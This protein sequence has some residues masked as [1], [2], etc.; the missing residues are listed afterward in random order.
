MMIHHP[1]NSE[2]MLDALSGRL[3]LIRQYANE[4]EPSEFERKWLGPLRRCAYWFSSMPL[5]PDQ[6][7]E[8]GGAFRATV[9]V[10]F[11]AM[12]LSGGQKFAADQPSERRRKIEPQY[13]H[14]LFL[15]AACSLLDEPCRHFQFHR[16]SDGTE[17]HPAAH[18]AFGAWI[19][20]DSYR[21]TRRPT[22]GQV[23]RM[24]TALLAREILGSDL[25]SP[26]D[27]AVLSEL[28]GAI[29]PEPRPLGLETLLQKVIRQAIAVTVDFE[30]K[31][32][33][34]E[35]APDSTRPPTSDQLAQAATSAQQPDVTTAPTSDP[36]EAVPPNPTAAAS[37]AALFQSPAPPAGG[38]SGP[39]PGAG[40]SS[41]SGAATLS[42]ATAPGLKPK[43]LQLDGV[44]SLRREDTPAATDP[45]AG[46][47]DNA[48][49]LMREF[50]R[51]LAQDVTAGKVD[52]KWV[53]NRLAV[54]KR[55]L[56][57]YG[58]TS[59]TLIENLR[60]LSLLHQVQ[61]SEILLVERIGSLVSPRPHSPN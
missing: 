41:T 55:V 50:F 21:V 4:G 18:G 11:F 2:T 56:G 27:G 52:V 43:P 33:R 14:G 42:E 1:M 47:L 40:S 20:Q 44:R 13:L 58:I 38:A 61:G 16:T 17:W 25:L 15:A 6:H 48:S 57:N 30:Q 32:R 36:I 51:A 29:N 54:Q 34:A 9:E 23:E 37:V 35:F 26:F 10:A 49:N 60:K 19:G 46:I 5:R 3:A 45:F 31:A 8:P 28:F 39:P 22:A 12:R 24:R 59:D 53:E 7:A